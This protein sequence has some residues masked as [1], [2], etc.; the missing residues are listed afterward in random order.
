MLKNFIPHKLYHGKAVES[1]RKKVF[2][3]KNKEFH[4]FFQKKTYF[5]NFLK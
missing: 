1:T 4:G 2:F 3:K 5:W